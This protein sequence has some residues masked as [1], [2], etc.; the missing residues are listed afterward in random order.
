MTARARRRGWLTKTELVRIARWKT[1]R[2]APRVARNAERRVR[3]ATRRSF[4][5]RD[6]SARIDELTRLS[7]IGLPTASVIL[8]FCHADPYPIFDVRALWS[9]SVGTP[10]A[11][12]RLWL[13]Y[14]ETCRRLARRARCSMRTLD[15]AL[16]QYAKEHAPAASKRPR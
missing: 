9:L 3:E 12:V 10:R 7:G 1:P 13:C 4:S 11:G 8:H 2:S 15:R 5:A 6:E 14:V 16:W